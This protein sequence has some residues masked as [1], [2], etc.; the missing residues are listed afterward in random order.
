MIVAC[1]ENMLSP[2]GPALQDEGGSRPR[3]INSCAPHVRIEREHRHR[4]TS[5]NKT[6]LV[7]A[8]QGHG[9]RL[10]YS[11]R[12]CINK[13]ERIAQRSTGIA[14][15][16]VIGLRGSHRR[17]I[18]ACDTKAMEHGQGV[19]SEQDKF[20]MKTRRGLTDEFVRR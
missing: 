14:H 6:D 15:D 10:L 1:H 2:T 20:P 3:S 11:I 17:R 13:P 9:S 4:N 7:N 18:I 16:Q 5:G 19:N 8:L 12:D